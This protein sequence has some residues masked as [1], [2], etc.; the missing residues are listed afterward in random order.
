MKHLLCVC[1]FLFVFAGSNAQHSITLKIKDNKNN[2]LT[3]A[4][5]DLKPSDKTSV[6]DS[7]GTVQF[8]DLAAGQY[9]VT[10]TYVGFEKRV[11][12]LVLPPDVTQE[13]VLTESEEEEEEVVVTSTR[14][15]RAFAN[16]P[17]RIETI[18]G[19][20]LAEKGNMKP[21]DIR[22][23]L[24]EST[25]IQ[26][27]Q[28]SATSYNSS[29]R[30]QGLDGRYTQLLRD[31][32]PLYSGFAGGLSLMQIAPLDLKQIEVIKGSSSTLYGGGAIAGLVNLISKSPEETRQISFMANGTSANGLDLS[33]FYSQRFQKFGIT[34]F[35]SSNSG[36]AYDPAGIGLTAI[37]KFSR[38]TINPKLFYYG[39]KTTANIGFSYINERRIGGSMNYIKSGQPGYFERNNSDRFTT[40]GQLIR[41]LNEYSQIVLKS[42]FSR[43]NRFIGV[44]SYSFQGLQQST[45]SEATYSRS[46]DKTD[47]VMG[48]NVQ[49]DHFTE[50]QRVSGS[51]RNYAYNVGG[52]FIQ[53]TWNLT[54]KIVLE[55]GLRTDYTSQ[56]KI[57]V[58]P[59]ISA[60]YK[61]S[62][63]V[64]ARLGGGSG[65]KLPT[66]FNEESEKIQLQNILPIDQL[67]TKTE[68]SLGGNFDVNYRTKIGDID[69]TANQLFF[70]TKLNRPLILTTSGPSDLQ[71]VN[72]NG[73]LDTKGLETNLRFKYRAIKLFL[74]YTYADVNTHF[75][76]VKNWYALSARHRLNNVL[77]IE[78]EGSYKIGFEA[79]YFSKQKL[80][81]GAV[82]RDYWTFGLMGEKTWEHYSLFINLENFTDTRQTRFDTIFSGTV[83]NPVFRDIY[84]P[85]DGFVLNG[86]VKVR[87]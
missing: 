80:N 29:I 52:V 56:F 46:A 32:L 70:F 82:G 30:I 26:T 72:A 54:E 67:T 47:W 34:V 13:I 14:T 69:V 25:G 16:I 58:L 6:S 59:R 50:D 73:H 75:N 5:A 79:Y 11:I 40:Q 38:Y 41:R 74:G 77:M 37:P 85:T 55:S 22:M 53:N 27:Q 64:T 86:G 71:F 7:L 2:F 44:P 42:S 1:M 63:K 18:S 61:I 87:L 83:Q 15:T 78:K 81:D 17:T 76:Q 49:T 68:R 48:V 3:G 23:I 51:L 62:S 39:T 35:G 43:F 21:G 19:E 36:R 8:A 20:E 66:V 24:G 12:T 60:M 84:A 4:T 33:A 10:I 28:T 9:N 57:E 31:G 65:Y 45:Y